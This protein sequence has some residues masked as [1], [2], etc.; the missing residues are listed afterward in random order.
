MAGGQ[1]DAQQ[2]WSEDG[3]LGGVGIESTDRR[4]VHGYLRKN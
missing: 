3:P 1:N 4:V 2:L